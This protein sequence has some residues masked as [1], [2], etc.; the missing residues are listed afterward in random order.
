MSI[1]TISSLSSKKHSL[2]TSAESMVHE[3]KQNTD[4][5]RALLKTID[6]TQSHLE[7]LER[8]ERWERSLPNPVQAAPVTNVPTIIRTTAE[9]EGVQRRDKRSRL[10]AALRHAIQYGMSHTNETRDLS[11][12][13]DSSGAAL[14][15]QAFEDQD[16]WTRALANVAPL[17][18]KIHVKFS[19]DGSN[20]KFVTSD[21]TQQFMLTLGETTA[22]DA[23]DS[24]PTIHSNITGNLAP[25][26]GRTT[27]SFQTLADVDDL[28][29]YL[30]DGF[31]VQAARA[32]ELAILKGVDHAGTALVSSPVGGLL[33]APQWEQRW[34]R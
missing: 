9:Q 25:I 34:Q 17:T 4:E 29:G 24:T 7:G 28:V 1:P 32:Q 23:A 31:A 3:G 8:V 12:I 26:V 13:S 18:Q 2:I 20:R 15:G 22:T 14:F 30:R 5:Y 19:P 27:V 6:E 21:Q 33:A 16:E 11:T 10:N